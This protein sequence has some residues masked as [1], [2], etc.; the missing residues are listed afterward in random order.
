MRLPKPSPGSILGLLVE[1]VR[2]LLRIDVIQL[3]AAL[4]FYAALSLA[5]LVV[6]SL[7][8]AGL[9]VE[10]DVLQAHLIANV[11][12]FVGSESGG[13][14]RTVAQE[15]EESGT[16][17]LATII[18]SVM[19]VFSASYVFAQLQEGLN[20]IWGVDPPKRRAGLWA[21]LRH[22]LVSLAMVVSLGFLLLVSLVVSSVMAL[23]S[24]RLALSDAESVGGTLL[25]LLASGV[26]SALLF[27]LVF[28]VLPDTQVSWRE[29][30]G[31]AVLTAALFH[32]GQFAI[33]QYLGRASV[34]SAYGAAGALVVV[35]V[36][37]YYSSL[38][39]FAGAQFA[40]AFAGR[41]RSGSERA[42]HPVHASRPTAPKAPPPRPAKKPRHHAL[43]SLRGN[44]ERRRARS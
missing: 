15:E 18:G 34:G 43:A 14:I 21:F 28:K 11:E 41:R 5:P 17:L 36:W 42:H 8:I 23:L 3:S 13:L 40:H 27:T 25:H 1:S 29:A 6:V 9:L 39:V 24:E 4:A 16:G 2:N 38:I 7:G 32:V 10:R 37:V 35:L 33:G 22:R 44:A 12:R 31:G 26:V 20:A 30:A 19:L